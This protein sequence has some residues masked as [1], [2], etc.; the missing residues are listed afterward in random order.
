MDVYNTASPAPTIRS[1]PFKA[2]NTAVAKKPRL[3]AGFFLVP[4]NRA[5]SLQRYLSNPDWDLQELRVAHRLVNDH[6]R[7]TSCRPYRPYH[8]Y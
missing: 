4:L 7:A 8:P 2:G 3:A 6:M 5:G 1:H